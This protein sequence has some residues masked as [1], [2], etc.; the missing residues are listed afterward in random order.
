MSASSL[1]Q[2]FPVVGFSGSRRGDSSA[3]VAARAFARSLSS[4]SFSGSVVVGC[5]RGVDAVVREVF[6]G[7]SVFKAKGPKSFQ[8]AA[9][10]A[11]MV[12]SVRDHCGVLVAFPLGACPLEV[13][14]SRSFRGCGSGTWGSVALALGLGS[15][16]LVFVAGLSESFPAP[17]SIASHFSCVCCCDIGGVRGRWW[18]S[19]PEVESVVTVACGMQGSL[20]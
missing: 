11:A 7:A 4:S 17:D 5:A 2:S 13:T 6:S 8:L 16:V 12:S 14:P 19:S 18:W 10:S 20:F 3:A 15:P 9:R 1:V